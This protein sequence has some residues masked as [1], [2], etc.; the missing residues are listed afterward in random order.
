MTP[1]FLLAVLL[2]QGDGET[3]SKLEKE[4]AQRMERAPGEAVELLRRA[5]SLIEA[6]PAADDLDLARVLNG[7]SYAQS[8]VGEHDEA[9][10]TGE[11]AL[12]TA[13]GNERASPMS[14]SVLRNLAEVCRLGG[15]ANLAYMYAKAAV[16]DAEEVWGKSLQC[17]EYR[18]Y[19][20]GLAIQVGA[21]ETAI[22]HLA[23]TLAI[24]EK[25]FGPIDAERLARPMYE[26]AGA[27]FAMGRTQT[28]L[29]LHSRA[30]ALLDARDKHGG[31]AWM[32]HASGR[33]AALEESGELERARIELRTWIEFAA[34]EI[35]RDERAATAL[36]WTRR[37]LQLG[38]PDEALRWLEP[39]P[40]DSDLGSAR[41]L[42]EVHC[43]ALSGRFDAALTMADDAVAAMAS[44]GEEAP[45]FVELEWARAFARRAL[46][47]HDAAFEGLRS[48]LDLERERWGED[49]SRLLPTYIGL[50]QSEVA[51]RRF[52]PELVD[53]VDLAEA[54][55]R[56]MPPSRMRLFESNQLFSDGASAW[57]PLRLGWLRVASKRG[58]RTGA[59]LSALDRLAESRLASMRADWLERG[60]TRTTGSAREVVALQLHEPQTPRIQRGSFAKDYDRAVKKLRSERP[61]MA[62]F[63]A[64][65]DIE[66]EDLRARLAEDSATLVRFVWSAPEVWACVLPPEGEVFFHELGKTN[67][68]RPL[69]ESAFFNLADPT[70]SCDLGALADQLLRPIW[71]SL[72][73]AQTVVLVADG[74]LAFL[75]F[76]ALP[77]PAGTPWLA[78][79]RIVNAPTIG[80]W[81]GRGV[82]PALDPERPV[83]HVDGGRPAPTGVLYGL[84]QD[85]MQAEPELPRRNLARVLPE[86]DLVLRSEAALKAASISGNLR[87]ADL[88]EVRARTYFDTGIPSASGIA[89]GAEDQA[90]LSLWERDDGFLRAQEVAA[91]DLDASVAVFWSGHVVG[92]RGGDMRSAGLHGL[93]ASALDAGAG[94]VL[95]AGWPVAD[96]ASFNF[97]NELSKQLRQ[98]SPDQALVL[99]QRAWL[100]REKAGDRALHPA[101]WARLRYFGR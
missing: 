26:I 67:E 15:D 64:P 87:D 55:L 11:R 63:L 94:A 82:P 47:N 43:T 91:L 37:W 48:L 20:A 2:V 95:V 78:S 25:L 35:P 44:G 16:A 27:L 79:G 40:L 75:P 22:E 97:D 57:D 68:L 73:Q 93:V 6:D 17:A 23:W 84:L 80:R 51:L 99:V 52:S 56:Y 32:A 7:L 65:T 88:I 76:E 12:E 39:I 62:R 59:C 96:P 31:S 24:Y 83:A 30:L 92:P 85:R 14:A 53:L 19:C 3:V 29:D 34:R 54:S 49:S 42:L 71:D 100:R 89:L 33:V 81:Y 70:R 61:E 77:T 36:E 60:A 21:H 38:N 90:D 46:G 28:A 50:L 41:Q 74:P 98:R 86:D 1:L 72:R 9:R 5:V 8:R 18:E 101:I 69:L 66:I 10:M 58:K 4:A 45:V 13:R